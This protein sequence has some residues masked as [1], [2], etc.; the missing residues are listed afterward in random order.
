MSSSAQ[1]GKGPAPWIV[2]QNSKSD[3]GEEKLPEKVKLSCTAAKGTLRKTGKAAGFKNFDRL[4]QLGKNVW[5]CHLN[6]GETVY[7][8]IWTVEK[9]KRKIKITYIGTHENAPY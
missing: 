3:K 4:Q 1:N 8:M 7:V 5:H 6:A 9:A 2:S